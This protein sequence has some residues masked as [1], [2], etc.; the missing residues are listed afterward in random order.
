MSKSTKDLLGLLC[1]IV[2]G[3]FLIAGGYNLLFDIFN[4]SLTPFQE[5]INIFLL[6]LI[7]PAVGVAL[8][9]FGIQVRK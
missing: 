7:A 4:T 9:L 1:M 8:I 6:D 3:I 2:G 5:Y